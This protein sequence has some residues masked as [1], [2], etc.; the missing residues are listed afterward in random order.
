[1]LCQFWPLEELKSKSSLSFAS[2]WKLKG[3]H[4][5]S[6]WVSPKKNW[7]PKAQVHFPGWQYSVYHHIVCPEGGNAIHD[8]MG[9][10]GQKLWIWAPPR[11][12]PI[13]FFL[14]QNL[15]LFS[16]MSTTA[17]NEFWSPSS[18]FSNPRMIVEI[19]EFIVS[20]LK[21]RWSWISTKLYLVFEGKVVL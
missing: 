3:S 8:S 9:E 19:P 2:D 7:T 14:W 20:G 16:V 5:H 4:T 18:K 10:D 15:C 13:H 12:Y 6:M 1:M 21:W 17:F 11:L